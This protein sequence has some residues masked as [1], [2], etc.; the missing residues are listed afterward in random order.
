ML[1]VRVQDIKDLKDQFPTTNIQQ[2]CND[3]VLWSPTE[4]RVGRNTPKLPYGSSEY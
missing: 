4:N 3:Y 1:H 2:L